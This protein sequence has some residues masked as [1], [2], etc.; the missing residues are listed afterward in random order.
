MGQFLEGVRKLRP[1]EVE[2]L[3][4]EAVT[5]V[6]FRRHG[7]YS[8]E[9]QDGDRAEIAHFLGVD[10]AR[11]K[12]T[13][14]WFQKKTRSEIVGYIVRES[15]LIE[16][17]EFMAY[18]NGEGRNIGTD[19]ERIGAKLSSWKKADLVELIKNCGVDLSGRLPDE[20]R[21]K[22]KGK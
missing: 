9:F 20:I 5:T 16:D 17:S 10:F 6:A 21:K 8:D 3:L 14:E 1:L 18:M 2:M 11:W 15:G 22:P 7:N 19:A 12:P 4:A 13:D